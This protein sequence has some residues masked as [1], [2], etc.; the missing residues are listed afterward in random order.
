MPINQ[1]SLNRRLYKVLRNRFKDTTGLDSEGDVTPIEDEADVFRFTFTKDGEEYGKVYVTV[2]NSKKLKIYYDDDVTE[3]PSGMTPGSQYNDTWYGFTEFLKRWAMSN[4]LGWEPT[5]KDQLEGDMARRNHVKK[6]ENMMEGY[7]PMGKKASYSDNVPNV[8]MVIQHTREIQ[9]GEQRY[10]NVAKIFLENAEGERILAPTTKPGIARV[11]ARHIAE[12]GVPN[13]ERWNHIKGLCEE[14]SKMA[15]FVRATRGK[16]FNESAQGLIES[17]VNHY[18]SLRESLSKLAG[19]R[20]YNMYF[21][22]WTPPLMED[23]SDTSSITELFVQETMDPRIESVMPILSKLHKTVA[24][25][26]EVDA[27]AE[28]ADS[29]LEAPGAETL[30][31]NQDTEEKNLKAFGLAEEEL[32]EATDAYSIPESEDKKIEAHGVHGMKSKPW[33]KV[34][35]NQAAFQAWLEKHDG[36]VEVHGT[37][38]VEEQVE[39]DLDA[40][41]KRVGQLGPTEKVGKKGA[42]GKLV[43]A[44]ESFI[45]TDAQAVVTEEGSVDY[46][47]LENEYYYVID[48]QTG[49][50]VDGPFDNVGEVPLRLMGFDGGHKVKKGAELKGLEDESIS[51]GQEDL[52]AILRIIKK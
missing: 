8:K 20:G 29:L 19:H 12:G 27:L 6:Q 4:Q 39:E 42:V 48:T 44:S 16:Q 28:W 41:Q 31:H 52:D 34:F 33:R 45:N 26:R 22:S 3:S 50:V 47:D 35:K 11:Y 15:G 13:D 24:E 18:N 9:E 43:G 37:R 32:D 5:D 2:D 10:R 49:E 14:Y 40:N 36:D 7:Y 1:E 38:E 51:E 23:D 21:E 17:G 25:M 30:K 46:G